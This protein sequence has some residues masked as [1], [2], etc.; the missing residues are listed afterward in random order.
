[1]LSRLWKIGL[2]FGLIAGTWAGIRIGVELFFP[3]VASLSAQEL[4][5]ESASDSDQESALPQTLSDRLGPD[6][7]LSNRG[8]YYNVHPFT[9][10]EGESILIEM[11]SEAFDTYLILLDADENQV[12]ADDDGGDGTN[13]RIAFTASTPGQYLVIAT[14]YNAEATGPYTLTLRTTTAE[15]VNQTEQQSEMGRLLNLGSQQASV[16]QIQE[17]LATYQQVL[18]MAQRLGDRSAESLAYIGIGRAYGDSGVYEAALSAY[19]QALAIVQAVGNR[20]AEGIV[21]NNMG[22]I[23][24]EQGRYEQALDYF[25]RSLVIRIEV[26]DRAGEGRTLNNMGL[27]YSNLGQYERALEHHQRVLGIRHEV[28]DRIGEGSTL[29]NI[30]TVYADTGQYGQAI[31]YFQRALAIRHEVGDRRGEGFTLGNLGE[32]YKLLGQYEEALN[33]L[34]QALAIRTEL[35]DRNGEA[36]TLQGIGAVYRN[37]RQYELALDYYQQALEI[38]V[39]IGDRSGEST[40]L[41]SLGLVYDSLGQSEQA[42]QFFQ[43][44]LAIAQEIGDRPGEAVALNNIGSIYMGLADYDQALEIVQV[45][46]SVTREMG[47]QDNEGLIL[48]NLGVIFELQGQ[49]EMAIAFYKASVNA[50]EI[51]RADTLALPQELQLSYTE[52]VSDTYRRLADLL[53]SQGR[54]LEA[55]QVLELLKLEELREF[56]RGVVHGTDMRQVDYSDAELAVLENHGSIVN[57]GRAIA[58][59]EQIRPVCG[60][61]STLISQ[62]RDLIEDY[63]QAVR[64]L[65]EEIRRRFGED[66]AALNPEDFAAQAGSV[67]QDNPHTMLIYPLVLDDKIWLLWGTSGGVVSQFEVRDV[68]QATLG[69]AV[70]RFRGLMQAC[71]TRRCTT[72]DL[73]NIQAVAQELYDFLIPPPLA[74]ELQ[75]LEQ[76]AAQAGEVPN[77]V[78][79]LDRT[80]RYLPPAALF[81]GD[82]YLVER[83]TISTV[84]SAALT[85]TDKPLPP[86]T[87]ASVLALGLSEPVP[88]I[89]A[90]N[91]RGFGALE[92]VPIEV[93][94]IV[95]AESPGIFPGEVRLNREFDEWVFEDLLDRH[96][97]HIATHGEFV[98]ARNDLS[99]LML[100]TQQ[101]LRIARIK[102]WQAEFSAVSLV[103]LSACETA[104]GDRSQDGVEINGIAHSFLQAGV[105]TVIASLWQV[106][107]PATS[108]LMQAFYHALAQGTETEPVAIAQALRTAQL[109]MLN[110]ASPSEQSTPDQSVSQSEND[111]TRASIVRQGP[112]VDSTERSVNYAHPYYWSPFVILGNGL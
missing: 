89:P 15:V 8:L 75:R 44:A 45:S 56:T 64:T 95:Q 26:G 31:D 82:R 41:N 109:Q 106:N 5:Q 85:R 65:M 54:L 60:E 25:Q 3:R 97:L 57:L 98:P 24:D 91:I 22:S 21:L 108:D 87:E 27:V 40:T 99:Y 69:D 63:N 101:P 11:I 59:C 78:F 36:T 70:L 12:A 93:H 66:L 2:H 47:Q 81:D 51:V 94:S 55:Q 79:A 52:K 71:E 48:S 32:T 72:V 30:G 103:V 110:A 7:A 100:G 112:L 90:E 10:S 28:G 62:R 20:F 39:E 34:Q 61:R 29:N 107:D 14:S 13:A 46:L 76:Q 68:D 49:V 53:L 104:L 111:A 73:P 86:G 33:Y 43:N 9:A 83:F 6:S 77:L 4:V 96:I 67:L 1:M 17:A 16:G 50:Y 102:D 18:E 74:A 23:Y 80:I 92:Y 105:N 58:Q 42:L 38:R 35:G 37:L 88:P 84:L 19:E